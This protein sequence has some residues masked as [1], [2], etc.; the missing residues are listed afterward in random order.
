[1]DKAV[2]GTKSVRDKWRVIL[3]GGLALMLAIPALA[4][5]TTGGNWS[6]FDHMLMGGLVGT[7]GLGI[8][9]TM[10]LLRTWPARLG[11]ATAVLMVFLVIW[12][13]LAVGVFGTPFAG[14]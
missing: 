7:L 9:L 4:Q 1:M 8:E 12:A 2:N 5:V 11:A 14:S 10:R 6:L 3:W 13:E